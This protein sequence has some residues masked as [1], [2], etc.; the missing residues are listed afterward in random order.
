MEKGA[1]LSS[2]YDLSLVSGFL[3]LFRVGQYGLLRGLDRCEGNID[4]YRSPRGWLAGRLT[5]GL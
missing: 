3:P 2:L 5:V 4:P 1:P